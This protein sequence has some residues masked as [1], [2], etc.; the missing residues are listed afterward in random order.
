M[1]DDRNYAIRLFLIAGL[2]VPGIPRGVNAQTLRQDA[3][4]AGVKIGAA[5]NP[6]HLNDA[7]YSAALTRNF[8]LLEPENVMKFGIIHPEREAFRFFRRRPPRRVC[9]DERHGS[10]RTHSR[11][12]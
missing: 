7:P 8:N 6:S 4:R 2:A 3:D 1:L 9:E 12:A 5:V 11:V 10:S